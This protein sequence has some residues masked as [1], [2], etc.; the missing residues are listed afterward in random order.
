MKVWHRQQLGFALGQPLACGGTLAL[1]AVPV[2]AAVV[3][4]DGVSALLVLAAPDMAAERRRAAALDRA[5]H[6]HLVEAD[7]PDVGS[8]PRRPGVA[9]DVRALQLW[10]GHGRGLLCRR[11]VLLARA[12]LPRL[13]ARLPARL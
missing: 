8:P 6:L 1:G 12:G 2:A 5:H 11:L 13:L 4:D 9:E 7:V 3:S 10:T